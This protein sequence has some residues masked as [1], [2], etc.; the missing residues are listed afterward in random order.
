M[1]NHDIQIENHS[2]LKGLKNAKCEKC[3]KSFVIKDTIHTTSN[4]S[5]GRKRY[6][7]KCWDLKYY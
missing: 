4:P 2:Q 1:A 6:H 7:K 3:G 5:H